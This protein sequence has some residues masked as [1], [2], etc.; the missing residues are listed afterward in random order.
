M[1]YF[2]CVSRPDP[3][4]IPL[5]CF[6]L[7]IIKH[8]ARIASAV[9]TPATDISIVT[10]VKFLLGLWSILQSLKMTGNDQKNK[11]E[12]SNTNEAN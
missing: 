2:T 10:K 9:I 3:I 7:A 1:L 12:I 4:V 5:L 11:E 8:M 6:F